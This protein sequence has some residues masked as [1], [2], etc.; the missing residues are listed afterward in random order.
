MLACFFEHIQVVLT[1]YLTREN[2]N[3][4]NLFKHKNE[5]FCALFEYSR[6][7]NKY[8][9]KTIRP[10][11]AKR[12]QVNPFMPIRGAIVTCAGAIQLR[13][14]II[15]THACIFDPRSISN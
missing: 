2:F 14:G 3:S 4:V 7:S 12:K 13:L 11:V 5:Q 1:N 8:S 6:S 9:L 10:T 15:A